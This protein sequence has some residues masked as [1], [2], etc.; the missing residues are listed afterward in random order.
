MKIFIGQIY[1][2]AGLAFPFSLRFQR[3]LGDCLSER[4]DV[5]EQFATEFGDGFGLGLRISA[6]EN[7]DQP[8]IKGPT[9]FKRDKNVEFT[10]FLPYRPS[11]YHDLAVASLLLEQVL[12]SALLIFQRL[13]L[14]TANV[15]GDMPHLRTEFLST[16]G[17]LDVGK[18]AAPDS[19]PP[20]RG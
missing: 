8:E 2:K 1:I 4:V 9:V 5:S 15:V 11:N 12:Q 6:K 14:N 13:G 10:I 16:P 20:Q 3:W 19:G 17:L 18:P 7:I